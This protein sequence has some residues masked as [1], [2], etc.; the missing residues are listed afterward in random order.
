MHAEVRKS[1]WYVW[2]DSWTLKRYRGKGRNKMTY[3]KVKYTESFHK[4]GRFRNKHQLPT[5]CEES[6]C[7]C[8]LLLAMSS[9]SSKF[10]ARSLEHCFM[11]QIFNGY[12]VSHSYKRT[13]FTETF[14]I[15]HEAMS[16]W[17]GKVFTSL[18]AQ[19]CQNPSRFPKHDVTRVNWEYWYTLRSRVLVHY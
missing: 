18:V 7:C 16:R 12:L 6:R 15:R 2:Y 9:S 1:T 8:P 5:S 13:N 4:V 19:N 10:L 17:V 14:N 11:K 3:S